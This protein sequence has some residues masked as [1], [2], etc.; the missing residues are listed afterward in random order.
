MEQVELLNTV[1][2]IGFFFLFEKVTF[3]QSH[4]GGKGVS[5]AGTRKP[6]EAEG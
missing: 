4:K 6:F 2:G 3:E 1:V 5:S